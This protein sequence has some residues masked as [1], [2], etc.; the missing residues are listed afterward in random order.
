[1]QLAP[2]HRT[3]STTTS[4]PP[5]NE[6]DNNILPHIGRR[7]QQHPSPHRTRATATFP[8]IERG[9]QQ[10]P[11]I[12]RRRQSSISH[13]PRTTIPRAPIVRG[14]DILLDQHMAFPSSSSTR[15]ERGAGLAGFVATLRESHLDL[16]L[17]PISR[18][19]FTTFAPHQVIW[20]R[21]PY[22]VEEYW[23]HNRRTSPRCVTLRG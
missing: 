10:H 2:P 12:E 15:A 21:C 16:P 23:A 9:R 22:S 7:R 4:F 1:M 13:R 11:P 5:S 19:D 17:P 6:G 14:L 18:G 3:R 20:T 8:P